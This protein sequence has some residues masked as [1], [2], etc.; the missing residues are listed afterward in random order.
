MLNALFLLIGFVPLF[1]GA[2]IF[3]DA[4][5]SLARRLKVSMIV[6]GLTVVAFGTS[7]PELVVNLVAA[8]EGRPEIAIGNI[9]GSNI[10][11][12]LGILGIS[13]L[14][15]PLAV[16]TSTTRVEIPLALLSAVAVF[17]VIADGY[18]DGAASSTISRTDGVLLLLFFLIFIGYIVH[19]AKST[20]NE[21]P[22]DIKDY[23]TGLSIALILLGLGLL[24]LG[25]RIIVDSASA[26]ARELGIPDRI[27]AIT[28]VSIGTSLPELA[29][30]IVAAQK[31]SVDIA[32]GNIVGSNIFNVFFILGL[33]AV[34]RPVPISAEST[35]DVLVNIGASL[36]LLVF[37]FLGKGRTISRAEGAVFA[38]LY[39]GYCV[40]LAALS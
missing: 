30:S 15:F 8:I 27:I 18:F 6:I 38:A 1:L 12:I 20:T 31:R 24:V 26:F 10:F 25:G 32:V 29:T 14:I 21:D 33:T 11:N 37:V 19:L 28:I 34:V 36:L 35:L 16:R 5:A 22:I 7:A 3:V 40:A 23:S 17:A 2:S 9:V 39:I 13:A 4:A